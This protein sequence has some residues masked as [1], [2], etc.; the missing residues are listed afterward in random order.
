LGIDL[1]P[2][3]QVERKKKKEEEEIAKKKK[4]GDLPPLP[5]RF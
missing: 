4:K 1:T 2:N 5:R 3:S